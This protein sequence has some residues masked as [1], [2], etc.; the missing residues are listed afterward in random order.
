MRSIEEVARHAS[1]SLT[2]KGINVSKDWL[3]QS[4]EYVSQQVGLLHD[5]EQITDK[6][7]NLFLDSDLHECYESE[8]IPRTIKV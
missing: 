6:I 4:V 3:L 7:Y 2:S 1:E 5:I 8:K